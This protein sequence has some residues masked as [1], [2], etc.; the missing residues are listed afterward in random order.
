MCGLCWYIIK[1]AGNTA[2][3][4][5]GFDTSFLVIRSK[6]QQKQNFFYVADTNGYAKIHTAIVFFIAGIKK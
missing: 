1:T 4:I 2:N 5:A 3:G 6:Y